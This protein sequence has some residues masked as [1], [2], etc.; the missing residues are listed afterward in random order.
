MR[1]DIN[2]RSI[3][4][5]Q[6]QVVFIPHLPKNVLANRLKRGALIITDVGLEAKCTC[7][8]DYW[9][10]D[11]EFFHRQGD[12]LMGRCKACCYDNKPDWN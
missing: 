10:F 8:N 9:P 7:C 11:S 3:E 12:K 4:A 5:Y 1:L 2:N 6:S